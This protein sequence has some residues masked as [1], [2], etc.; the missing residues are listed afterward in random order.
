[1]KKPCVRF[2]GVD[3]RGL[4]VLIIA[5]QILPY[6]DFLPRDGSNLKCRYCGSPDVARCGFRYNTRGIARRY[7]CNECERK[8]SIPHV[9]NDSAAQPSELAWLL[10]EIGMLTS[11]LSELLSALNNRMELI[12]THKS[13]ND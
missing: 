12:E 10:N 13:G 3:D 7:R 11:K 1:M 9:Q 4:R 2:W 5:T 8:F 6:F